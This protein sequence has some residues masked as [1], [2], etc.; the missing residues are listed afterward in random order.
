M[1]IDHGDPVLDAGTAGKRRFLAAR[2]ARL[3]LTLRLF[4]LVVIAVLPA[5]VIQ[6]YNE[7]DLRKAR[8][9]DIRRQVI[10]TTRQFGE[11]IGELREGARQLL[12]A[13][14]QLHAV[15][16]HR[17]E[18]CD[19]LFASLKS[20]YENY[21]LLAAADSKGEIFCASKHLT[22]SSV[23]TQSFFRRAMA[24]DGLAVGN[25][26]VDPATGQKMVH[27][28][29]KFDDADGR[30]AGVVFAGLDLS[31]L[32][33]HLR[34]RGL[35]PTSSILIA[36]RR[37]YIIARLPHPERLVG[38]NMRKSHEAIMDG[39]KAG[40]EETRGV[41]GITRIFGYVPPALPPYD[42]FLSA[43][44]SKAEA[45]AAIEAATWR[46]IALIVAGLI[47]A[48]LAAAIG[49]R[50][51]LIEPIRG[52]L[53][54]ANEWRHGNEAARVEVRNSGSEID[55]LGVTFNAMADALAI[56]H[57]AQK[58]AEEELRQLNATL[59]SRVEERTLELASANRA[60]SAFLANIS[61]EL[62]TPLNA[63]I[64]FGEMIEKEILGPVGIPTYREYAGHIHD[65]GMHLLRLVEA[66]LDLSK[67]EA[68]KLEIERS[69]TKLGS[70]LSESLAMLRIAA[71]SGDVE[72][73]VM[74][75]PSA[76]PKI[77]GDPLKL[78]QVLVNLID[79]AIKFTPAGGRITVTGEV[80]EAWLRVRITDTGIGMR[81][82]DIPLVVQPFY[83]VHSAYDAARQG[84]GLG[85]PFAKAVIELH[86]GTFDIESRPGSGTTVTVALP[87]M[88]V[89]VGS[90]PDATPDLHSV[91]EPLLSD[92]VR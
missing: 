71:L 38:K 33:E 45:F 4:I 26:W 63:T 20:R 77:D 7:Y 89:L 22:Y 82:E 10:E 19:K 1:A 37:G 54:A 16:L 6:G 27:F 3:S 91:S 29:V 78:K 23:G 58:Q 30:G 74:A 87:L 50:R 48:M 39:D 59:E 18:A 68:G 14:G 69:P 60:K 43:G 25:Y 11:E 41:D 88:L 52:L 40:S 85:L 81:A 31:W 92:V 51:F 76:W 83:R 13:L 90:A 56:R 9:A 12:I 84:A 53:H 28:A 61:H 17:T 66:M 70:L 57:A 5:I 79:N 36:D 75:E 46:G 24:H 34:E 65:S 73:V 55:H 2:F 21:A 72:I 47:A 86:G 8:E 80:D 32:S 42:F 67:V 62:R 35:S 15:R 64:G 44:Q 49:G